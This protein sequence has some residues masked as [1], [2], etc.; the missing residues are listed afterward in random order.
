MFLQQY[1]TIPYLSRFLRTKH[2]STFEPFLPREKCHVSRGSPSPQED[3]Q[4]QWLELVYDKNESTM[5]HVMYKL[6]IHEIIE[7]QYICI[8]VICVVYLRYPL[9]SLSQKGAS[10]FQQ[11]DLSFLLPGR[12]L[13]KQKNRGGFVC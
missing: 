10:N 9:K 3:D 7:H 4:L 13:G 8:S 5:R 2:I 6:I 12:P 1:L 11:V